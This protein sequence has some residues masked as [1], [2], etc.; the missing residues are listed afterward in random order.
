MRLKC[1]FF[2]WFSVPNSK[3]LIKTV[4]QSCQS[5][6]CTTRIS[7]LSPFYS[8]RAD[9]FQRSVATMSE[10]ENEEALLGEHEDGDEVPEESL[11]LD[12]NETLDNEDEVDYTFG[13][14]ENGEENETNVGNE[15]DGTTE[16]S[17][18][19]SIK[20]RVKEMEEEAKK[21]AE[22]QNEV[23]KQMNMNQSIGSPTASSTEDK[24]EADSRSIY[25]GNVS[26]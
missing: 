15:E 16:E 12:E 18:L 2:D 1:D 13:D 24:I 20:A 25:V 19:E 9:I 11:T 6:G 14:E 7:F 10:I 3:I 4:V 26:A 8:A 5:A 21:L 17:D 23:E 22:M